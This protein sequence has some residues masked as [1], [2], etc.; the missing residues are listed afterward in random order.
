M[1][2]AA[3]ERAACA[4]VQ[5]ELLEGVEAAVRRRNGEQRLHEAALIREHF[6]ESD[7]V[8]ADRTA[9]VMGLTGPWD[10]AQL[11]QQSALATGAASMA[12]RPTATSGVARRGLL[13]QEDEGPGAALR[14]A[15]SSP[16]Q[17]GSVAA[18][19]Q[20]EPWPAAA[21]AAAAA[22]AVNGNVRF[23]F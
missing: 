15:W 19:G 17:Q 12:R 21:A 16:R 11:P 4:R 23:L 22:A 1:R 2:L 8:G 20:W 7:R 10:V 18:D 6:R 5:A 13:Y 3:A 14:A 9:G